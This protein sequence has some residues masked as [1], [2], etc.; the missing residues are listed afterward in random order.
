MIFKI[1]KFPGNPIHGI[2]TELLIN[3]TK[4][5]TSISDLLVRHY[6]ISYIIRFFKIPKFPGNPIHGI[7]TKS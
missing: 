2:P 4:F 6:D 3:I 5:E 1:S 7:P